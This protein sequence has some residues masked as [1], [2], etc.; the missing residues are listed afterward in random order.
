MTPLH[1]TEIGHGRHTIVW[2]HGIFGQGK[3]FTSVARSL[4]GSDPDRWR[5][6]LV[7]LPNH[8]RSPWTTSTS[9]PDMADHL[10][11]TIR[12]LSPGQPV[13]LLGHSMGGK[14]A[15]RTALDHPELL[16]ALVVVDIS[17]VDYPMGHS[18]GQRVRG[19]RSL[20]LEALES[21]SQAESQLS[22]YEPDAAIRQFLMQNLRHDIH[23]PAGHQWHWQMNLDLLAETMD[24]LGRW[25]SDGTRVWR[26]PVLW[27]N[28][29]RSSYV[30]PE[31]ADAMQALFP[32]VRRVTIK[33][34][35]H[36][37]HSDQPTIFT[38]VVKGFLTR[39]EDRH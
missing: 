38:Q 19:M 34:S 9:Y 24:D 7:D 26:G 32:Q 12:E 37:V 21:R 2:C 20:D 6:V 36:W 27:I 33:D 16:D 3:N 13:H 30:R 14:V 8:G 15:M 11:R 29:A 4:V 25:P 28:G 35:G 22:L 17:P 31:Y 18:F 23:A 10:A 1:T 39:I 5:C